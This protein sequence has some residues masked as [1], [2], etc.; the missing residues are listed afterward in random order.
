M[1]AIDATSRLNDAFKTVYD[2][3]VDKKS[4]NKLYKTE[5]PTL[6]AALEQAKDFD[7]AAEARLRAIAAMP[8]V[9]EAAKKAALAW[10]ANDSANFRPNAPTPT[11]GVIAIEPSG[12]WAVFLND[13]GEFTVDKAGASPSSVSEVGNALAR[14]GFWLQDNF[15]SKT[16]LFGKFNASAELKEKAFKS[17][18]AAL[19]KDLSGLKSEEKRQYLGAVGALLVDLLKSTPNQGLSAALYDKVFAAIH[20]LIDAKETPPTTSNLLVARMQDKQVVGGLSAAQ[21]VINDKALEQIAPKAPLDYAEKARQAARDGK[22]TINIDHACGD[23]EG[24]MEGYAI[25]L[26]SKGFKRQDG[27]TGNY[28]D[29][30]G[31]YVKTVKANDPSNKW[32]VDVEISLDLR[33]MRNDMYKGMGDAKTD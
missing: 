4:P 10:I 30:P 21:K 27:A 14:A 25:A 5:W 16:T 2:P 18:D 6:K 31:V 29:R 32:G 11:G 20:K 33:N 9:S 12:P 19:A 24:F 3:A 15:D 22:M 13:K 26:E 7:A 1:P 28:H 17:L 23:G 8:G